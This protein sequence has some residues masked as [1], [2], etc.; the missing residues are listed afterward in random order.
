MIREE[1]VGRIPTVL[2]CHPITFIPAVTFLQDHQNTAHFCIYL[3]A[4]P[5]VKTGLLRLYVIVTV[6]ANSSNI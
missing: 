5:T 6:E 4:P 2:P 1:S 3:A